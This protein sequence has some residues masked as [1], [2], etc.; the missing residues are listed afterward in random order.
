LPAE[1][2]QRRWGTE[3]RPVYVEI[4]HGSWWRGRSVLAAD[5]EAEGGLD[6]PRPG[7]TAL[8]GI[9]NNKVSEAQTRWP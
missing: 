7:V 2:G 8:I 3:P 6:R 4:R 1:F 9:V 5:A